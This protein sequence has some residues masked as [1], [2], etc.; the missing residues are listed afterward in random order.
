MENLGGG[1]GKLSIFFDEVVP[2]ELK[3]PFIRYAHEHLA[4]YARDV[5]RDRRYVCSRCRKAVTDLQ[6][7]RDRLLAGKDFIICQNCD[8]NVLLIDHVEQ[9]LTSDT[10][11]RQVFGMGEREQRER[12][13]QAEEQILLGHMM[14]ICGE[15]NQFFRPISMFDQGIDGEVEFKD[16]NGHGSG[17]RIYVQLKSGPSYLRTRKSDGHEVFDVK[18]NWHLECW[19]A[20]P[21]DVYLVIRDFQETIRWMNITRYLKKRKDKASRQIV[22]QGEKLNAP[23][24]WRVRDQLLKVPKTE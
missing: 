3:W 7:V 15:A 24:L 19:V 16:N 17:K 12:D 6:V 13:T 10:V 22:F 14:A 9:M 1:E 11:S 23:A 21:V 2:D 8:E 20:Q 4:R 5:R 18:K